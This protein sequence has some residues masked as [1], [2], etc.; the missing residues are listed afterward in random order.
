MA[1]MKRLLLKCTLGTLQYTDYTGLHWSNFNVN[2]QKVKE[3]TFHIGNMH[4]HLFYHA[5]RFC[6]K[7]SCN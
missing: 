1:M 5:S 4:Q 7:N 6:D 2:E 3:I